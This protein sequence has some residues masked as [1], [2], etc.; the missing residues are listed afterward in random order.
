MFQV[1]SKKTRLIIKAKGC[2]FILNCLK[3]EKYQSENPTQVTFRSPKSLLQF[4]KM[5]LLLTTSTPSVAWMCL[6]TPKGKE[7]YLS[8]LYHVRLQVYQ[9]CLA[10]KWIS[11][12]ELYHRAICTKETFSVSAAHTW[13]TK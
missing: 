9:R 6:G 11:V 10:S 3:K 8:C 5:T 7:S 12:L 2:T 13:I 1:F 4:S